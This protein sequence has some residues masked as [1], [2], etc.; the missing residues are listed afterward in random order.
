[1]WEENP[2]GKWTLEVVNDGRAMVELKD[3]GLVIFGTASHPQPDLD[4]ASIANKKV[5]GDGS[6]ESSVKKVVEDGSKNGMNLNVL[7]KVPTQHVADVTKTHPGGGNKS[8]TSEAEMKLGNIDHCLK[9]DNPEWC[10]ICNP[11]FLLLNGRC[12]SKCPDEGFYMGKEN[13]RDACLP[14]YYSCQTCSGPNDYQV[15]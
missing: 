1:M 5:N 11:D 3:W 2:V 15:G 6:K 8:P 10:S 9:E 4:T 14:C 13:H 7:P 12:V